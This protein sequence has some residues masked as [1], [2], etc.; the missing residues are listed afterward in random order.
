VLRG[1]L[2]VRL[3]ARWQ[4]PTEEVMAK[5]MKKLGRKARGFDRHT[6]EALERVDGLKSEVIGLHE[7]GTRATPRPRASRSSARATRW[8]GR[9]WPRSSA[10]GRSATTSRTGGLP[11]VPSARVRHLGDRD[12]GAGDRGTGSKL[13]IHREISFGPFVLKSWQ[14]ER[15]DLP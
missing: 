7:A 4:P 9:R 14:R 8:N 10:E 5:R 2:A 3:L 6:R 1:K 13:L 15:S 12:L 11:P